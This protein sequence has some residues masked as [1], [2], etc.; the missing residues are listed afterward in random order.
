MTRD[1]IIEALRQHMPEIK[2]YGVSHL[3]VFGSLARGEETPD[4]DVDILVEFDQPIGLFGFVGLQRDLEGIIGRPVD[5]AT[6]DA[7]RPEMR[8][9]I[10]AE[11]VY[12]A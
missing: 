9:S 5:L 10:L 4:S 3:A 2:R 7:L 8:E 12:A 1:D 11:A 6:P